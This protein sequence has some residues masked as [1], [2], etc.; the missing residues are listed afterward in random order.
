MGAPQGR[1]GHGRWETVLIIGIIGAG[2]IGLASAERL[3]KLDATTTLV[4]STVRDGVH[5]T[6]DI[7]RLIADH[8][9]VVIAAPL[10]LDTRQLVD[11]K[12]LAAMPD[13]ALLINVGRGEIVDTDALI[14]E[15]CTGRLR[16]ALDVT[17][18]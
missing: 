14:S 13:D 12:F 8:D 7:P 10:T 3:R 4:A 17:R 9:I 1:P 2:H 5:G 15:L 6:D 16:A 11:Q 18:P